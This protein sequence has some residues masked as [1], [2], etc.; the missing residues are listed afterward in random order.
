MHRGELMGM[1][2]TGREITI[3]AIN[4]HRVTSGKITGQW[5]NSDGLSMLQQ[6]GALPPP[7]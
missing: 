5:V 4:I 3:G 2:P 1:F 7:P 6:L